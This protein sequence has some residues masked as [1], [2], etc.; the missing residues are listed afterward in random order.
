MDSSSHLLRP[1]KSTSSEA[2]SMPGISAVEVRKMRSRSSCLIC[3]LPCAS[4]PA[5]ELPLACNCNRHNVNL[6]C[7]P[8]GAETVHVQVQSHTTPQAS[9]H[10]NLVLVNCRRTIASHQTLLGVQL[11]VVS[12]GLSKQQTLWFCVNCRPAAGLCCWCLTNHVQ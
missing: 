11:T 7:N 6:C 5:S 12:E 8:S 2:K 3:S 1:M 9:V 10:K 4:H